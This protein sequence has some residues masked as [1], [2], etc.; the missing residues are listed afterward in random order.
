MVLVKEDIRQYKNDL[1]I[2]KTLHYF[3]IAQMLDCNYQLQYICVVY[4]CMFA[5]AWILQIYTNIDVSVEFLLILLSFTIWKNILYSIL[6]PVINMND[7][8]KKT[9][10]LCITTNCLQCR[11]WA[12]EMG[13][14]GKLP[15]YVFENI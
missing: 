4:Y 10:L 3:Q 12:T 2:F 13:C 8:V 14:R 1:K 6:L 7:F 5:R 15:S 11:T 9:L